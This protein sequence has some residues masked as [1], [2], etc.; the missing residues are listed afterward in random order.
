MTTKKSILH[1]PLF[2]TV[3][4]LLIVIFGFL[5]QFYYQRKVARE[6]NQSNDIISL[7]SQV[8]SNRIIDSLDYN[9]LDKRILKLEN[10]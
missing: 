2:R 1:R 8:H 5:F 7:K 10:K 9:E 6:D 3:I 4:G